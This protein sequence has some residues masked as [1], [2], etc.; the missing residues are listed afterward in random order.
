[1]RPIGFRDHRRG[2]DKARDDAT[3]LDIAD[4]NDRTPDRLCETHIGDVT[5]PKVD[6]RRTAGPLDKDQIGG[7]GQPAVAVHHRLQQS[8]L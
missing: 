8:R 2:A 4:K 5:R 6:L 7:F 3:S 1:M